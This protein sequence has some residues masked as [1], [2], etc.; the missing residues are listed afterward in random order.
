MSPVHVQ[1]VAA[2]FVGALSREETYRRTYCLG[3]A[4][5]LSWKQILETIAEAAGKR[6]LMWPVPAIGVGL[7]AALLER[8]PWF[9]ITRDQITMLLQ[10]N[11][12]EDTEIFELLGI[13]PI[14]FDSASLDYLRQPMNN[15]P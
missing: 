1:D 12:C 9:P 3:G 11:V 10:G 13:I 5:T 8:F 15:L 7:A 6:K 2:A 14:G 4:R